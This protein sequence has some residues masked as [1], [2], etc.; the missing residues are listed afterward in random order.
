MASILILEDNLN[1]LGLYGRVLQSHGHHVDTVPTLEEADE[2]L[3]QVL[4]N[5]FICDMNIGTTNAVQL[6]LYWANTLEQNGTRIAIISS[7]WDYDKVAAEL[8]IEVFVAKPIQP[9]ELIPLV[10]HLL[11]QN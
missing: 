10:D 9:S 1:L 8:G 11:T 6:L 2:L 5:V 4:Y 3:G 7:D